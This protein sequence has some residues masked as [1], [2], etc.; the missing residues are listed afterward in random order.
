[1]ADKKLI[2]ITGVDQTGIIRDTPAHALPP[3]AWSDGRNI[4]FK[5]GSVHKRKGSIS[6]FDAT[7]NEVVKFS[8]WPEP[9]DPR[10]L[11]ISVENPSNY[12]EWVSGTDY[13]SGFLVHVEI[14]GVD[15]GYRS[16]DNLTNSTVAPNN[17]TTNW[18]LH[19]VYSF[20]TIGE[21]Q[22]TNA[23]GDLVDRTNVVPSVFVS[24][25]NVTNRDWQT[26]LFTGGHNIIVNNGIDTP[27]YLNDDRDYSRFIA[28]APYRIGDRVIDGTNNRAYERKVAGATQAAPSADTTNWAQVNNTRFVPLP[29]WNA[30]TPAGNI[31]GCKVIRGVGGRLIAGNI[32]FYDTTTRTQTGT[33]PGTVRVSDVAAAGRIPERWG[34]GI[35]STGA[36]SLADEF[37]IS[38]SSAIQDIVPLQGQAIIYTNNSIHSLT[39]DQGGNATVR[40]VAEGYGA[41]NTGTVLEYDGKHVV[42]GSNDIFLFGVHPGSIESIANARI[43]EYFFE[44]LNPL[45]SINRNLFLL[46]DEQLDEIHIYYPS[47][48][49]IGPCDQYIAWNYRNNTWTINDARDVIT[50]DVGPIRGGGVAEGTI[51]FTSGVGNTTEDATQ[52]VQTLTVARTGSDAFEGPRREVQQTRFGSSG[53]TASFTEETFSIALDQD[54][55]PWSD[56]V[57]SVEFSDTFDAGTGTGTPTQGMHDGTTNTAIAT[58]IGGNV[59]VTLSAVADHNVVPTTGQVT[60]AAGD[61]VTGNAAVPGDQII[62]DAV[63]V[64]RTDDQLTG[65]TGGPI[66]IAGSGAAFEGITVNNV[67]DAVEVTRTVNNVNLPDIT[68]TGEVNVDADGV[69]DAIRVDVDNGTTQ[70]VTPLPLRLDPVTI[71]SHN[72]TADGVVD[73]FRINVTAGAATAIGAVTQVI[74][75][76][77]NSHAFTLD[78]TADAVTITKGAGISYTTAGSGTDNNIG[79]GTGEATGAGITVT[80]ARRAATATGT[81]AGLG[82]YAVTHD[83]NRVGTVTVGGSGITNP[84]VTIPIGSTIDTALPTTAAAW[85][86]RATAGTA[87]DPDIRGTVGN[88]TTIQ[89]EVSDR[90][91]I[92][93]TITVGGVSYDVTV[94]FFQGTRNFGPNAF[95]VHGLGIVARGG[96]ADLPQAT[97]GGRQFVSPPIIWR[98][99]DVGVIGADAQAA[100]V[101]AA[102]GRNGTGSNV[103]QDVAFQRRDFD[104]SFTRTNNNYTGGTLT[105]N[106]GSALM[107]NTDGD[108]AWTVGG[109]TQ[110]RQTFTA[111]NLPPAFGTATSSITLPDG[112][113]LNAGN[114]SAT[115][116]GSATT[117]TPSFPRV[118]YSITARATGFNGGSLTADGG[119]ATNIVNRQ[120][121]VQ[122]SGVT[123]DT[124]TYT[125]DFNNVRFEDAGSPILVNGINDSNNNPA[126]T[127]DLRINTIN[128]RLFNYTYTVDTT[129]GFISPATNTT[130]LSVT[131]GGPVNNREPNAD[132][133]ITGLQRSAYD[134]TITDHLPGFSGGMLTVPTGTLVQN[135]DANVEVSVRDVMRQVYDYAVSYASGYDAD[136]TTQLV[137]TGGNDSA[138]DNPSATITWEVQNFRQEFSRYTVTNGGATPLSSVTL[139]VGTQS[140]SATNLAANGTVVVT[141]TQGLTLNNWSVNLGSATSYLVAFNSAGVVDIPET[142]LP[143]NATGTIAATNLAAS[144]NALA[145]TNVS[146]IAQ[147]DTV[148]IFL[149]RPLAE[150]QM[151]TIPQIA[152][153]INR[154]NGN[155]DTAPSLTRTAAGTP[156]T[157]SWSIVGTDGFTGTSTATI[158]QTPAQILQ[159]I[160]NDIITA[161]NARTGTHADWTSMVLPDEQGHEVILIDT[162]ATVSLTLSFGNLVDTPAFGQRPAGLNLAI[163]LGLGTATAGGSAIPSS[164]RVITP[165]GRVVYDQTLPSAETVADVVTSLVTALN[166]ITDLPW[167]VEQTTV[168]DRIEVDFIADGIGN[169]TGLWEVTYSLGTNESTANP[170]GIPITGV[171]QEGTSSVPFVNI[172]SPVNGEAVRFDLTTHSDVTGDRRR[173]QITATDL[174]TDLQNAIDTNRQRLGVAS[175]TRADAVLTVTYVPEDYVPTVAYATAQMLPNRDASLADKSFV[176]NDQGFTA[177]SPFT[178]TTGATY[179][180]GTMQVSDPGTTRGHPEILRTLITID[181]NGQVTSLRFSNNTSSPAQMVTDLFAILA[182]RYREEIVVV[183]PEAGATSLTIQSRS[184][185]DSSLSAAI[186]FDD[187]TRQDTLESFRRADAPVATSSFVATATDP[188]RPW[189]NDEFNLA[190]NYVVLAGRGDLVATA[191]GGLE[192]EDDRIEALGF[193]YKHGA[194]AISNVIGTNYDSYVE[195]IHNSLDGEVEYT[196]AAESVQLLLSDADVQIRL[197]M[198]DSPGDETNLYVDETGEDIEARE[199]DH[200]EDYKVDFRRHGRLFN[201]RI[202]DV[203]DMDYE[204]G[205]RV[206][207]YGVSAGVEEQRG[208]RRR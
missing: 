164:L 7:N 45:G 14:G 83:G 186:R 60:F 13:V 158:T 145:A 157:W 198:T 177:T 37:E 74:N 62:E 151:T 20:N 134:F 64:T 84:T 166:A 106:N 132:W 48:R 17:D 189:P 130:N 25:T 142:I 126:T 87:A 26:T 31:A 59:G 119:T 112:T 11:E 91:A 184:L 6:A 148:E 197:G 121:S 180:D 181:I 71:G 124:Y 182:V 128:R 133:T 75:S 95:S 146:A 199:F 28:N 46:R 38:T 19:T 155:N 190:Q 206:S 113:V 200:E 179:F 143:S 108:L 90:G 1:M 173:T 66:T 122:L 118:S 159:G 204:D 40:T 57:L 105:L 129:Q 61:T 49:S 52:E 192:R 110:L 135:R 208:G 89:R 101:N 187:Q 18:V 169:V 194:N 176:V 170:F 15:I 12:P 73:A 92:D 98:F 39:F 81:A 9:S 201:I 152:I 127:V 175:V 120:H 69:T 67:G 10:Y 44:D 172:T 165:D 147:G 123:R 136:P 2:P 55:Q 161:A 68:G 154:N 51:A 72:V 144:I 8:Y 174:A 80:D 27:L 33:M 35:N 138:I 114:L 185:D 156:T 102:V 93:T 30:L 125:T 56:E 103:A 131:G 183:P 109:L 141:L 195:R 21:A 167:T 24:T 16:L 29:D 188:L 116:Q 22:V 139:T 94:Y 203:T 96:Q 76:N 58:D 54:V 149:S 100:A 5:D 171:V 47:V 104:Y 53:V 42:I 23:D 160:A 97:R 150:V 178:Y 115:I 107:N 168:G 78:G 205:W 99:V 111:S 86:T 85:P 88:G 193:G 79:L 207:G 163:N 77:V 117:W 43:R 137:I 196:K 65:L 82:D 32:S 41:L 191:E 202:E 3:N 36:D 50:G 4:R 34:L 70:A 162:N 153:T 140:Q 63:M